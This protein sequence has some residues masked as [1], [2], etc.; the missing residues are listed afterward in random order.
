MEK[1]E[2]LTRHQ[3]WEQLDEEVAYSGK[4]L[5]QKVVNPSQIRNVIRAFR[6]KLPEIFPNRQEV[7]KT[8]IFA[9][10]GG[11]GGVAADDEGLHC[12]F[13]SPGSREPGI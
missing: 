5:D 11:A 13:V 3:R 7:P 12:Y 4:Q 8:L 1:R 2:K 10:D 6:D 9:K